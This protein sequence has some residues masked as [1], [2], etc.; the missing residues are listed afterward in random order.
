VIILRRTVPT[1]LALAALCVSCGV[2]AQVVSEDF[3][4]A[5]TN[6]QWYFLNGACLTAGAATGVEPNSGTG[7]V[8]GCT[9]LV[10]NYYNATG[11]TL[12]GG[13]NGTFPDP[14]GSG[15]LRLTNGYPFGYYENGGI[16]SAITFPSVQGV[17][18]TFKTVTY[19]GNSGGPGKDGADGISFF[20]MDASQLDTTSI[21]GSPSGD[22]NGIGSFGGSLGYSC[23]ER[24]PPY[25]G[26]IGGY[27][28][29][30]I[31]EYG[32]FLN[33]TNNTLGENTSLSNPDNTNSGGWFQ[34]GRIGLRGAGSIAWKSLNAL[35][36]VNPNDPTKPYYPS[37]LSTSQQEQ[38]VQFTCQTAN[39][40]N[41]SDPSNVTPANGVLDYPALPHGYTVLNGVQIAKESAAVRGQAVPIYYQL[42]ITQTGLLSLS[43]S[44]CPPSGCGAWIGVLS[45][46]DITSSNGPLPLNFRF[47]FAGS[48]GSSTNIHEILCFRADPV[49]SASSSAGASEK[50]S[51]ELETGVQAYFAYYNPNRGYSGRVTAT[52][53]MYDQYG[54]VTLAGIPNWDA[55]CVLTGVPAHQ[56]CGGTG[57]AGP[58][59]AELPTSPSAPGSRQILAWNGSSGVGFEYKNLSTAQQLAIDLDDSAQG[60]PPTYT[61]DDR[62]NYLRGG[63]RNELNSAGYGEFRI[64]YSVLGDIMD[65]SPT[66]VGTPNAPYP[67]SWMDRINAAV[68]PPENGATAQTYPVFV[69][70]QTNRQQVVYVGANDGMLHGFRSGIYNSTVGSCATTPSASCYSGN[71]GREVL[72][73]M[74]GS[75]IS[76]ASAQLIHP[77]ISNA[78]NVPIDFSNP[79]YGHNDFVDATPSVGDVFYNN[80]WH[81]LL[82]GGLGAGGAA[83]YALDITN[84][85]SFSETNA[86]A[87]VLGEWNSSTISCVG[88]P[89]CGTSLGNTFGTPQLRRLH[90]GRW[91]II[92]GNGFGS[93]SGDGGIY[94][95]VVDPTNG[96]SGVQFYYLSTGVGGPASPNG[97]AYVAPADLDGDHITDYIY[98]GDLQG[99]VWRFDVTDP[100]ESNWTLTP[101]PLFSTGGQPITTQLVLAS[102]SAGPGLPQQLMVL[103]GTGQQVGLTNASGATYASGTQSLYGVWDW[104]MSATDGGRMGPGGTAP[105]WN[106]LGSAQYAS[107]TRAAAGLTTL[108]SANLQQQQVSITSYAS[109]GV[110]VQNRDIKTTA[111]VCWTGGCSGNSGP[112]FGWYFNLPGAQEQVVYNPELVAQALTVNTVVPAV[113]AAVSCSNNANTGFTYVVNAMSGGPFEQVFLPPGQAGYLNNN[114]QVNSSPYT[115]TNAIAIETNAT[116][117]S[118]ITT[119]TAGTQYLVYQTNQ[120]L[121]PNDHITN[122]VAGGSLGLNLP[123]NMTG[124]RLSWIELR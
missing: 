124:K 91:G 105:G 39:L 106:G 53:L 87:L 32:N 16:I 115:D 74:P 48:S 119:N 82:V 61:V 22:G 28:G 23:S 62:V 77:D 71:D 49:P 121:A 46:Q 102:G 70:A 33:G 8:P 58:I 44:I 96:V 24:N 101:G 73:Y 120:I 85:S 35:Y 100:N 92:F 94:I 11:E 9:S 109:N 30:G 51:A 72:A 69:A 86:A 122:S 45:N 54:N 95:G 21:T 64:R 79:Q 88:N 111:S 4:Q 60:Y 108:T 19:L 89:G 43:Y 57:A 17:S 12:V 27:L 117:S 90:D 15:A 7:Q 67:A 47:G 63:R 56:F 107:L 112:Q 98:A 38:A 103:F 81:S 31:D 104:N 75:I 25:N 123:A 66:W 42:E 41:Y 40:W 118:F 113:N 55:S 6:N 5:T 97:I 84:P 1:I 2:R 36:G 99:N 78:G 59:P 34:P 83:L 110:T 18:I 65:S 26:L 20:L 50:Q 3:T 76:G 37:T 68:I 13:F 80:S 14:V 93:A 10:G 114:P 29:L 116:G 52:S